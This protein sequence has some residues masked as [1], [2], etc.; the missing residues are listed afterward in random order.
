MF[1]D[2]LYIKKKEGV[3]LKQPSIVL[4][5]STVVDILM[6][7]PHLPKQ[8][9][10]INILSQ[11]YSLGGCAFNAS[12]MCHLIGIEYTLFSP[13]G[14]GMYADYVNAQ[15]KAFQLAPSILHSAMENGCCCC[16]IDDS[17][18]RS[19][20]SYH[21]AEY[22]FQEEWFAILDQQEVDTV[23]VCGLEIE[24]A[25]GIHIIEYLERHPHLT[26]YFASGPRIQHIPEER[27]KRIIACSPILHLNEEEALRFTGCLSLSCAAKSLYEKTHNIVIITLGKKGCCYYDGCLHIVESTP[28]KQI[29]TTGAGDSH[30]GSII[31]YKSLGYTWVDTLRKANNIARHVVSKQGALLSLDEYQQIT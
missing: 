29:D 21:G 25:S 30:I 26:I 15:M 3:V 14:T 2:I 6:R 13:V 18:E 4:I 31:A 23:Y 8:Q 19:F 11:H 22:T 12:W 17:G 28:A 1:Y 20:L 27:M 5:G 9:E 10:D 7:V 16:L 24:E